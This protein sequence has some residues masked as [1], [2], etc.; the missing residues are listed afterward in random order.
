MIHPN[1]DLP[2]GPPMTN[3]LK[4]LALALLNATL[5]LVALCLFLAWK[6]ADKADQITDNFARNLITVAPLREDVQSLTEELAALRS[7]LAQV[8]SQSS[9]LSSASLQRIQTRVAQI[10]AR[11]STARQ[12]IT[13]LVEAPTLLIDY[14]IDA[15][16]DRLTQGINDIRSCS[17]PKS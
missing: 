7:D 8:S 6:V 17:P 4:N 2:K 15:S 1:P 13:K 16:A 9:D 11:M 3:T 5:I 12:S 14:A 10:D